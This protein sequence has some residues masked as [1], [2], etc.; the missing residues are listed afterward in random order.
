MLMSVYSRENI[1]LEP[2]YHL[3]AMPVPDFM[4]MERAFFPV[5]PL[6]P[7]QA[8]PQPYIAPQQYISAHPRPRDIATGTLKPEEPPV[9]DLS[10]R[11]PRRDSTVSTVSNNSDQDDEES[12]KGLDLTC[13]DRQNTGKTFKK[14][15]LNRYS[16]SKD[17]FYFYIQW[18]HRFKILC[19]SSKY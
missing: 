15:L 14:A 18:F 2:C 12:V 4:T 6:P 5:F 19:C 8:F 9:L 1:K 13:P 7:S 10:I 3:P 16:K 11:K 17:Q